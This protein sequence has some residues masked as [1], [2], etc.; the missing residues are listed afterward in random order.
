VI[1]I[2]KCAG[3]TCLSER[4]FSTGIHN[5][6]GSADKNLCVFFWREQCRYFLPAARA[7]QGLSRQ[8]ADGEQIYL[9]VNK[10][11]VRCVSA[12]FG[13]S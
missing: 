13:L 6:E 11:C 7:G 9:R 8:K 12:F 3:F 2:S 10:I 5:S 4:K 1:L